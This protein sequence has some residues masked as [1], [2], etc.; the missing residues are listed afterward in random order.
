MYRTVLLVPGA[1]KSTELEVTGLPLPKRPIWLY[2]AVLQDGGWQMAVIAVAP[3]RGGT[4][5]PEPAGIVVGDVDTYSRFKPVSATPFVS[6]AVATNGCVLFWLITTG[7]VVAPGAVKVIDAGGQVEKKPAELA[8][9]A[10]FAES[11]TEPG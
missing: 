3:A 2:E 7:F 4:T 10:M 9:F 11:N 5:E 1:T 8:A 6:T